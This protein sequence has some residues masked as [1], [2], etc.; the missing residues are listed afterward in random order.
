MGGGCG[1]ALGR[2]P[3]EWATGVIMHLPVEPISGFGKFKLHA[4][5]PP[6]VV[7][8]KGVGGFWNECEL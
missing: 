3:M 4:P 6:L 2:R 7:L 1:L 8:R 5:R